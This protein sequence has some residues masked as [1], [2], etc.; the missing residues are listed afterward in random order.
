MNIKKGFT[1]AEMI[2]V[3]T[4]I[5]VLAAVTIPS[6]IGFID[7]RKGKECDIIRNKEIIKMYEVARNDG[8]KDVSVEDLIEFTEKNWRTGDL[9]PSGGKYRYPV[10]AKEPNSGYL[11]VVIICGIHGSNNR[12]GIYVTA[13]TIQDVYMEIK[14]MPNLTLEEKQKRIIE[15]IKKIT[16]IEIKFPNPKNDYLSNEAFRSVIMESLGGNWENLDKTINDK[17]GNEQL[18]VQSYIQPSG[19]VIIYANKSAD[20]KVQQ[21]A[22]SAIYNPENGQWYKLKAPIYANS[23]KYKDLANLKDKDIHNWETIKKDLEVNWEAIV[24]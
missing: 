10:A 4:I 1:L 13:R 18:Y 11:N 9:C 2:I 12:E 20:G 24:P 22:A 8:E 5:A 17:I 23:S 6:M 3:L 21:W 7:D 16:G 19:D 14:A 15:E